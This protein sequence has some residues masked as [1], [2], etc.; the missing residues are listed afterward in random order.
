MLD[1]YN[2]DQQL[3]AARKILEQAKLNKSLKNFASNQAVLK[4]INTR[5]LAI[6]NEVDKH[7]AK[8]NDYREKAG[9]SQYQSPNRRQA[10]ERLDRTIDDL[11]RK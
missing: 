2:E 5:K 10:A 1:Q 6:S 7:I 11:R 3:D 4:E 8:I 9:M